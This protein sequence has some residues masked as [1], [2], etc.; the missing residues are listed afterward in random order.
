MRSLFFT[1]LVVGMSIFLAA[2]GGTTTQT[3]TATAAPATITL[4]TNPNPPTAG[5]V[6]LLF[7]VVDDQGQP[8]S[9]ADFDVIADHT[10][11]S[12][13][14]MHGKATDQG[15]GNYAIMTNFSM[16]GNWM[17]TVQVRKEAL[18]FKQDINLEI[19]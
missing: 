3:P 7:T 12:G 15:N 4:N 5:D 8:V 11:M 1:V 9:G 13:M 14:T 18:D 10:D 19:K 17:L 6:E 2:C 16:T